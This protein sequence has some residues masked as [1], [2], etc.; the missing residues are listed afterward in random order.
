MEN[1]KIQ[2]VENIRV[3]ACIAVVL[4]HVITG[5]LNF[6][7]DVQLSNIRWLLDNVIIQVLTRT[8]V[9]LFMMISGFLLL[10]P[11][12]DI[13]IT[14]IKKYIFKIVI[15]LFIF[16]FAFALIKNIFLD[17]FNNPLNLIAKSFINLIQEESWNHLWYL[18]IL[19][20]LYILLPILRKF[21]K[22]ASDDE[23]KF[24][25]IAL[26]I[27]SFLIP[28]I[29]DIFNLNITSFYLGSDKFYAIFYLIIGY[30]IGTNKLISKKIIYIGGIIGIIG[31]TALCFLIDFKTYYHI[32]NVFIGMY[33]V[34]LFE[35][36]STYKLKLPTNRITANIA[37]Y[38]LVIYIMHPFWITL[39]TRGFNIYPDILPVFIGELAFF[40]CVM[41]LSYTSAYIFSKIPYLNKLLL[42]SKKS[43]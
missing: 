41:T 23:I 22:Y 8:S 42:N 25:L 26:F 24:I 5:W 15:I 31:Y 43:R 6:V 17:G 1:K 28:T 18:Y 7:N 38:S 35:L 39:L 27:L 29:N 14:K 19:I 30:Y 33:A 4:L 2:W 11:D 32:S 3:F 20:G 37:N 21:I 16:G 36:F 12:K 34:F 13:N 40:V 10:N 9:P